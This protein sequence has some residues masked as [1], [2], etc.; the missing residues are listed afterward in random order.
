MSAE[1]RRLTQVL[2]AVLLIR[3]NC[4]HATLPLARVTASRVLSRVKK[5]SVAPRVEM[6]CGFTIA[7]HCPRRRVH[8][9]GETPAPRVRCA[10]RASSLPR[11]RRGSMRRAS[12]SSDGRKAM[13]RLGCYGGDK[14]VAFISHGGSETPHHRNSFC[15]RVLLYFVRCG[16]SFLAH[17]RSRL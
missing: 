12:F 2:S 5:S 1:I 15:R 7:T 14:N 11:H 9:A 17:A 8:G 6:V 3:E 16:S 13:G 10:P 4:L